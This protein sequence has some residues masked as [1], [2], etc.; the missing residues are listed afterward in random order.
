MPASWEQALSLAAEALAGVKAEHGNEAIYG[1]S[2]GWASAGRLHHG[3]SVL[4]RFLGLHGGYVDKRGN[5]SFGAALGIM[6]YILGRSDITQLVPS[7][8]EVAG[9]TQLMV[10]FGG[11]ALKNTQLDPGG[12]VVHDSPDW[13][14]KVSGRRPLFVSISRPTGRAARGLDTHTAAHRYRHDAGHRPHSGDGR[15]TRPRLPG[16]LLRRL[17]LLRG[18]S[19][20]TGRRRPAQCGVG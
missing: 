16:P 4:K 14:Q 3:P 11:A 19:A 7:W 10:M 2:Y 20:G 9:S 15:F 6:P 18:L 12:A 17:P 8:P 5:H 13:Y 1:G